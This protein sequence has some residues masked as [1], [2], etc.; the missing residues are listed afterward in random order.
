MLIFFENPILM[1]TENQL[2]SSP[3]AKTE[4]ILYTFEP[5]LGEGNDSPRL[6]WKKQ[7]VTTNRLSAIHA[8]NKLFQ[9]NKYDKIELYQ[10]STHPID[11]L[12][13]PATAAKPLYRWSKHT[14]SDSICHFINRP[15]SLLAITSVL[16]G[17]G[18]YLTLHL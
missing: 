3:S 9:L 15:S 14:W 2:H 6:R 4:Y 16:L 11:L 1:T 13:A 7:S 17:I 5:A 10:R 12:T 18:L 8:G